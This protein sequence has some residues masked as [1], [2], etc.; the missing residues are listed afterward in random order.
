MLE[1]YEISREILHNFTDIPFS[2]GDSWLSHGGNQIELLTLAE[3][4]ASSG[5]VNCFLHDSP[6]YGKLFLED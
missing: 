1:V 2:Q 6:V 4:S 5:T 3:H